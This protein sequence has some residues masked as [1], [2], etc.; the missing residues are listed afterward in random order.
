MIQIRY[1]GSGVRRIKQYEWYGN[2]GTARVDAATAAE[3]LTYPRPQFAAVPQTVTKK[4]LEILAREIGV[5][6]DE[7]AALFSAEARIS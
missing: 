5:T 6:V 2:Y 3:L 1:L 7:A 4:D